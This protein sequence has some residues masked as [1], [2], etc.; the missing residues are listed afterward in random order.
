MISCSRLYE[1]KIAV[2]LV[3]TGQLPE[4]QEMAFPTENTTIIPTRG[5]PLVLADDMRKVQGQFKFD[6]NFT[7]MHKY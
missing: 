3:D 1:D 2:Y 7:T 4:L 5:G 6:V